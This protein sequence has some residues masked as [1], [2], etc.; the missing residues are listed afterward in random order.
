MRLSLDEEKKYIRNVVKQNKLAYNFSEL[1]EKSV[2]ILT[3]L[4]SIEEIKRAQIILS[5]WSLNDEVHTSDW[6]IEQYRN[7][8]TILLP[9]VDG[10]DLLIRHFEG[11]DSLIE[12]PPFGIKEPAGKIFDNIKQIEIVIVPGIAFDI[13]FNRL[14][15]GKGYYD[16]FLNK[17]NCLKIGICFDFQLFDRIPHNQFD[18]KMDIIVC[19]SKILRS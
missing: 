15:R 14:G 5:Y 2:A 13:H 16:R 6:N 1:S 11:L 10:N 9:S 4:N 12:Q 8:K 19:E 7:G 18:I 17:I 3:K